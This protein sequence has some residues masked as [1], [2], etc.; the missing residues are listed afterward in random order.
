MKIK[1][2]WRV[3]PLSFISTIIVRLLVPALS[4]LVTQI[5]IYQVSAI[6]QVN[7]LRFL[8]LTAISFVLLVVSYLI[9]SL[10]DYI[11]AK[12][13]E[14]YKA[15]LRAK[16]INYLCYTKQEYSI[17]QIQNFLTNDL[18]QSEENYLDAF[19]D[20]IGGFGYVVSALVLLFTIHW[21]M[22]VVI[23]LMVVI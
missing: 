7:L 9:E 1:D 16:I 5:G 19:F 22:L 13:K 4:L 14:R 2:F 3:N 23:S 6:Q 18:T 20:L 21:T 15:I 17:A 8:K 11:L 10:F 12:Q